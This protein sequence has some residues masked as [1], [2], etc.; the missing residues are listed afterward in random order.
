V[1]KIL[2]QSG[3]SLA[4]VYN[5]EG[6]IAGIDELESREVTLV[7]EMGATIF[8]ER[9]GSSIRRG[10]TGDVA[11]STNFDFTLTEFGQGAVRIVNIAVFADTAGRIVNA[12]VSI[13]N[14]DDREVPIWAWSSATDGENN[15]RVQVVGGAIAVRSLMLPILSP[16]TFPTMLSGPAQPVRV[17]NITFRGSTSG[18]GA[19]TV[20]LVLV[21]HTLFSQ[22]QG[23]SSLGLPIPGW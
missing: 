2:S 14:G 10:T 6:S 9:F 23:L 16:G 20:E 7:H 18:F 12:Q 22:S 5:V 21:I 3:M 8:S 1:T 17:P 4:D 19:G 11:Q 13:N 15:I